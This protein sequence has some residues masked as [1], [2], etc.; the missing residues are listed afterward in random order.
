MVILSTITHLSGFAT[1]R[2]HNILQLQLHRK[3]QVT[4]QSNIFFELYLKKRH[5]KMANYGTLSDGISL[6][7]ISHMRSSLFPRLFPNIDTLA[8]FTVLLTLGLSTIVDSV[9][10]RINTV[11]CQIISCQISF[12]IDY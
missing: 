6:P 1:C 11:M 10:P 2:R 9:K 12:F 4:H 7:M 8:D 3:I 5:R